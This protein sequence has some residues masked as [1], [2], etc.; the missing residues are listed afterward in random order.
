M[1]KQI[2]FSLLL[3]LTFFSYPAETTQPASPKRGHSAFDIS[4]FGIIGEYAQERVILSMPE[5]RFPFSPLTLTDD[6]TGVL[7]SYCTYRKTGPVTYTPFYPICI[8]NILNKENRIKQLY[9]AHSQ[10]RALA[11]KNH[12]LYVMYQFGDI[13]RYTAEEAAEFKPETVGSHPNV[14]QLDNAVSCGLRLEEN[15][16]VSYGNGKRC[17]WDLG[18]NPQPVILD[19]E[20]NLFGQSDSIVTPEIRIQQFA[21]GLNYS[22]LVTRPQ[23]FKALVTAI[24]QGIEGTE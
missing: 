22:L 23:Q 21:K 8:K 24:G 15:Q 2:L 10:P 12:V 4:I 3:F 16:L 7:T 20:K 11:Y 13:K 5:H 9:E 17:A 18:S 19:C 14:Y 6:Q 1:T